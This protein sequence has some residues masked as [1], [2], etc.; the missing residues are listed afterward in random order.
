MVPWPG[1]D[2]EDKKG[3]DIADLSMSFSIAVT[4]L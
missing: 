2:A 1:L 4:L 3:L